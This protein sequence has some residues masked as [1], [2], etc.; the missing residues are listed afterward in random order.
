MCT[1]L[2]NYYIKYQNLTLLGWPN[3]TAQTGLSV[4][5]MPGMKIL[6]YIKRFIWIFRKVCFNGQKRQILFFKLGKVP[7]Q[8]RID[9]RFKSIYFTMNSSINCFFVLGLH[10]CICQPELL[11]VTMIYDVYN[12]SIISVLLSYQQE[13]NALTFLLKNM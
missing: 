13:F 9:S 4:S 10:N 12:I 1:T 3:I 11:P 5:I 6:P 8:R 7:N 2:L